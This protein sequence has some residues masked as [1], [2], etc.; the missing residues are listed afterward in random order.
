MAVSLAR[1]WIAGMP[2]AFLYPLSS[3]YRV[4]APLLRYVAACTVRTMLLQSL[5]LP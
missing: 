3:D 4:W 5:P 1:T 2:R